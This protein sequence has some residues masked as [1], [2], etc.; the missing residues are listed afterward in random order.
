M[1][2]WYLIGNAKRLCCLKHICYKINRKSNILKFRQT[3]AL[4]KA[5]TRSK[6][7]EVLFEIRDLNIDEGGTSIVGLC[8]VPIALICYENVQ[9]QTGHD[10]CPLVISEGSCN[11]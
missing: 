11:E 9:V 6:K 5:L 10:V 8:H 3:L 4:K 2:E 7:S 1:F